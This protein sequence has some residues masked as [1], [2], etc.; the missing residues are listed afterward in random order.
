MEEKTCAKFGGVLITF[1]EVV[2]L[3]SFEFGVSDVIP[4]NVQNISPLV[5]FL[6]VFLLVLWRKNI[7]QSFMVLLILLREIMKSRR[8]DWFNCVS[9]QVTSSTYANCGL[10]VNFWIFFLFFIFAILFHYLQVV[11]QFFKLNIYLI[12]SSENTHIC[13]QFVAKILVCSFR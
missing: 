6:C 13:F 3:Q 12:K 5:V 7:V 8:F 10:H 2:K 4:A 9:T 1:H 11:L